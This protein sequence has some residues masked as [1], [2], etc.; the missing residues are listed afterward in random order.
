MDR[1]KT[2]KTRKQNEPNFETQQVYNVN[3]HFKEILIKRLNANAKKYN[4]QLSR[5]FTTNDSIDDIEIESKRIARSRH[6]HHIKWLLI[7]SEVQ[8]SLEKKTF[9][10]LMD[11]NWETFSLDKLQQELVRVQGLLQNPTLCYIGL[12]KMAG[13]KWEF[14]GPRRGVSHLFGK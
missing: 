3:N 11:E 9:T 6:I 12:V 2:T 13:T 10:V 5:K 7:Q 1:L 14:E 4:I 8:S